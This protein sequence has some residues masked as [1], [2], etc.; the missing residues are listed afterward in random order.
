MTTSPLGR[1][2]L[3]NINEALQMLKDNEEEIIKAEQAGIDM[4]DQ[5]EQ[6]KLLKDRL[7]MI[8]RSFFPG[9]RVPKNE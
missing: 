3:N 7:T 4:A 8:K 2:D 9:G 6:S 5:K 1:E